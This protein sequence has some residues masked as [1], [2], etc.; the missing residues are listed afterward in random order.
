MKIRISQTPEVT[1]S[2]EMD[3]V[4][5]MDDLS[6]QAQ[7]RSNHFDMD[8]L[9]PDQGVDW[10]NAAGK[11]APKVKKGLFGGKLFAGMK[12]RK[13]QRQERR[14][15]RTQ[16]KADARIMKAGAKQTK[17]DAKV[18]EAKAK[19]E[20]AK[21]LSKGDDSALMAALQK[22]SDAPV[23]KGMST[24]LKIG[25]AVTVVAVLAIGTFVVIKMRKKK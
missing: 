4:I 21:A 5:E 17:A 3:G 10:V 19:S 14:N 2:R 1:V 7:I 11:P 15:I 12:E 16:S 8:L 13:A 25:I 18:G 22:Q 24:G 6:G 20:T 23:E 9:S